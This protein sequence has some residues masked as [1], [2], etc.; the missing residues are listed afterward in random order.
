[1]ADQLL[2]V[3]AHQQR[4]R[5]AQDDDLG[6]ADAGMHQRIDIADIAIDHVQAAIR[7]GPEHS[8]LKSTTLICSSSDWFCRSISAQQRAGRAEEAE[9]DDPPRFAVPALVA[10]IGGMDVVEIADADP[11]QGAD[12]RARDLV[13]AHHHEGAQHRQHHEG[14]RRRARGLRS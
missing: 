4:I 5:H 14:E 2:V 11:L 10:G 8:G 1:M 3:G 7:Q 13:A 9:D 12:Q 6:L